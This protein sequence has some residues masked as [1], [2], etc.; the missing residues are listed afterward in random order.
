MK[1]V[2]Q[3][4]CWNEESTI[5]GTIQSLP[6]HID[7]ISCIET[8]IIDDGSADRTSFIAQ[9]ANVSEVVQLPRHQGLAAAFSAGIEAAIRH[10]ADILVN[11]DADAQY[12]S[13][14]IADLV[15]PILNGTA[16][17]VVGDRLSHKPPPFSPMK[18]M[19]ERLGTRV[20]SFFSGVAIHD[21][22]SG[23]R[24]F[25]RE[26]IQAMVIHDEFSYTLE[27]LLLAGLKKF[28]IENV[29]IPINPPKRKSRLFNSMRHYILRSLIAIVRSYLMYH[30]VKFFAGIGLLFICIAL[31]IGARYLFFYMIGQ[32]GGHIQS[33][34]LL[35][36]LTSIGF[37]CIILGFLGDIV[38]ANR[39]LLEQQR[40]QHLRNQ[41]YA[42]HSKQ[43]KN[44]W[45]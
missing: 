28:R 16:D 39:R 12:P 33:L 6:A 5:F 20:V 34:I 8:V 23:F 26:V 10:D 38:A 30:P 32:G 15:R 2:I 41:V 44:A 42:A 22:A 4:P 24:A 13:Q 14:C 45:L 43:E 11:T 9:K 27:S 25:N 35:T 3:I 29:P 40:I 17:I 31:G 18:M 19:L 37:Q 36:I 1:L 21:A 7:G